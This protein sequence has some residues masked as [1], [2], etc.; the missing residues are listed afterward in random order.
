[1]TFILTGNDPKL[2]KI[3]ESSDFQYAITDHI[4]VLYHIE[5][6]IKENA[7]NNTPWSISFQFQFMRP[8][9]E[10]LT[11]AVNV[12]C[13]Y[14]QS[15]HAT[16]EPTFPPT[17]TEPETKPFDQEKS[18]SYGQGSVTQPYHSPAQIAAAAQ[19][20]LHPSFHAGNQHNM[21]YH[22]GGPNGIY[23]Q[24]P[25]IQH[26]HPNGF[27]GHPQQHQN[28]G[29]G[30]APMPTPNYGGNRGT[31][32]GNRHGQQHHL[33][34]YQPGFSSYQSGRGGNLHMGSPPPFSTQQFGNN[35]APNGYHQRRFHNPPTPTTDSSPSGVGN[36]GYPLPRTVG[37]LDTLSSIELPD[38]GNGNPNVNYRPHPD[39]HTPTPNGAVGSGPY[40]PTAQSYFPPQPNNSHHNGYLHNQGY[41]PGGGRY[42][43]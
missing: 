3:V 21:N 31:M 39:G 43:G 25:N 23:H 5:L 27:H 40:S 9:Y 38:P 15:N 14:V 11:E 36:G 8:N 13:R 1:M 37:P 6:T 18:N 24:N 17:P 29:R 33:G 35:G 16:L 42:Q 7:D 10:K 19:G 26:G 22:Q 4:K 28:Y 34:L 32:N 20:N 41:P 2:A 12:L 30:Y